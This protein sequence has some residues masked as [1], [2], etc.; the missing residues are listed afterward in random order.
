MLVGAAAGNSDPFQPLKGVGAGRSTAASASSGLD[1]KLVRSVTDLDRELAAAKAAGRPA[2][3]DFSAEWCVS[4][5]E[6]EK[7]TFP[8]PKVKALLM[9]L[10]LMRADV[11]ENSAEDQALLKRFGI[12]GP[13]TIAFFGAD[14]I[15]RQNYRLVGYVKAD[16]FS[17]HVAQAVASPAT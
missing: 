10:W 14:G 7:Y 11:T 8:N 6:M 1:F 9:P 16:K 12:F 4:C 2:M 5:K 13:P 15:E 17:E 3:L